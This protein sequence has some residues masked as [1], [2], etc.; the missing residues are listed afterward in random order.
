MPQQI[1]DGITVDAYLF[2]IVI[3]LAA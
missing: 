2:T 1:D 3:S